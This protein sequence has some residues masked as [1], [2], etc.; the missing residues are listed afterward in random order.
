MAKA[1]LIKV[2]LSLHLMLT[3]VL[4]VIPTSYSD[5]FYL[6]CLG[7]A[8][9]LQLISLYQRHGFG[10]SLDYAGRIFRDDR[11]YNAG[12]ALIV[13]LTVSKPFLLCVVPH[14]IRATIFACR[15]GDTYWNAV[16][17]GLGAMV[18][19]YVMQVRQNELVCFFV[20]NI[21]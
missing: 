17:P 16:A 21:W 20:F 8:F 12:H 10:F 19:P 13:W 2:L 4:F 14:V 11:F 7:C 9:V 5:L 6:Q 1:E 3:G 18:A 15:Y